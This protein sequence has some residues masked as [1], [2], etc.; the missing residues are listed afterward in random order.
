VGDHRPGRV[1]HDGIAHRAGRPGE[2]RP[3]LLGVGIGIPADE[4]GDL[5]AWE[6][7][8]QRVE[9]ER[10]DG[11]GPDP[12]DGAGGRRGQLI[13]TIVTVHH[14]HAGPPGRENPRHHFS[15]V[16]EGATDQ[17]RP[18]CGRIGERPQDVEHRRDADLPAR[19]ARVLKRRMEHRGEAETDSHLG[20]AARHL[21]GAEIDPNPQCFKHVGAATSRRRRPIAVFDHRHPGR[22]HHDRGHGGQVHRIGP[23]AAGPD[24]I[25]GVGAD[26][27][28]RHPPRMGQHGVGQFTHLGGRRALHL[29]RHAEGGDLS[30]RCRPGHDLV[31]RPGSLPTDEL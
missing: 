17:P 18:R 30:R 26:H 31:H 15:Q 16:A 24:D 22:R 20:N 1:E 28:G 3:G 5:G 11:A 8:A 4:F 19:R 23:I 7:E 13:E 27:I 12:P 2:H 21:L 25:D 10:V 29:H 9:G 14:Q 6:T